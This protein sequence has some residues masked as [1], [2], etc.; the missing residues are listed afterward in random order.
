MLQ[1]EEISQIESTTSSSISTTQSKQ[2][3]QSSQ[4]TMP[5][6]IFIIS[7]A[8]TAKVHNEKTET[9]KTSTST[10]ASEV[11]SQGSSK[12]YDDPTEVLRRLAASTASASDSNYETPEMNEEMTE[13]NYELPATPE[14]N[15]ESPE[16]VQETPESDQEV[17]EESEEKFSN[18]E[19]SSF[20]VSSQTQ[21]PQY[22]DASQQQS[23]QASVTQIS[24]E[25][26]KKATV[27]SVV[28]EIYGIV[29]TT[30]SL[31]SDDL[32]DT[33]ESKSGE[34]SIETSE[35]IEDEKEEIRLK[36]FLFYK[37]ITYQ[38]EMFVEEDR[39]NDR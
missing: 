14:T 23:T 32:D 17:P 7:T 37:T 1:A 18:T 8:T 2:L 26:K 31:F 4:S 21:T 38:E 11:S 34:I 39:I 29:K 3:T 35:K 20:E 22:N 36:T 10:L 13:T 6:G 16:P 19:R 9:P 27:D 30:T 28:D 12:I 15:H 25:K 33:D 24:D 5:E